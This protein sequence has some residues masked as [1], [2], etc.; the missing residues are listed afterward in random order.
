MF[1]T[2]VHCLESVIDIVGEEL[3]I[4]VNEGIVHPRLMPLD[5]VCRS[6]PKVLV[7]LK[8]TSELSN[9]I[10]LHYAIENNY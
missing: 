9:L 8:L 7:G 1:H 5:P 2:L 4:D 6:D 10:I 3:G